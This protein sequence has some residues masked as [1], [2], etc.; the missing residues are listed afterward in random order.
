MELLFQK[1]QTGLVP[2]TEEGIDWLRKKKLGATIVVEPREMRNGAY[3]RKWWALVK[4]GYDYWS[5]AAATIEYRGEQVRPEFDRFRK[6]VT[7]M[8]GF[9]YPVVNLKGE[10]RIEPESLKWASMTEERFAKL[11]DATI[12]VLLQRVFNG[13]VCKSWTESEL[14]SVSDQILQF[15]A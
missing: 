13:T 11:Y 7:I 2:A 14:R 3:F 6:D 1:G 10:V 8:A 4:L 12:Q 9:Y 5:E 15:A